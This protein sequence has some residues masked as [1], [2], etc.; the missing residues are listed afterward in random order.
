MKQAV[1]H[2][3]GMKVCLAGKT[4]PEL[5]EYYER[6]H[7]LEQELAIADHTRELVALRNRNAQP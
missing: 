3:P 7:R 1:R 4:M 2:M 6:L 5:A